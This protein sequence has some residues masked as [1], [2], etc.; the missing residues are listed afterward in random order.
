MATR[1]YAQKLDI[2]TKSA[3]GGESVDGECPPTN[4]SAREKRVSSSFEQTTRTTDSRYV[5]GSN[6]FEHFLFFINSM[7][8][9]VSPAGATDR[10]SLEIRVGT[11]FP[12]DSGCH[13]Q[14]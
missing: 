6:R 9:D 12:T 10:Q 13:G 7:D 3:C 8:G 5:P 1:N 4:R 11:V 14:G 2:T